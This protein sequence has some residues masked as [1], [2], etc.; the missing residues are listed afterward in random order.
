[1]K[2]LRIITIL[3]VVLSLGLTTACTGLLA[4]TPAAP[5]S[6]KVQDALGRDV[7]V[8][9]T[10]QRV[11]VLSASVLDIVYA[12]G[13][14]VVG[15]PTTSGTIPEQ[16][17][18]VTEVGTSAD[19]NIE[20]IMGLQPDLIL[21]VNIAQQLDKVASFDSAK[22]PFYFTDSSTYQRT[23]DTIR[24]IGKLLNLNTNAEQLVKNIENQR[25]SIM[26]KI[27]QERSR[28]LIIFGTTQEFS[29][30]LPN[31]F[32]GDLVKQVGAHNI[33]DGMATLPGRPTY[34]PFSMER[35]LESDPDHILVISHGNAEAV[36]KAFT[37][38]MANNPTWNTLTAA[39]E[40]KVSV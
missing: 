22:I 32:V 18:A 26:D 40:G 23:I 11:V 9:L 33:A 6:R 34:A 29:F 15:R 21:G 36:K 25:T 28:V 30:A 31:S 10:P 20:K 13:G 3:L 19:I 2:A 24:E 8:T 5:T 14:S 7:D 38:Q 1:M 39:K 35:V 27:P 12:L 4:K 17:K 37:D 16:A